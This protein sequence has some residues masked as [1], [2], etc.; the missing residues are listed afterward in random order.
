MKLV[1]GKKVR[2][3]ELSKFLKVSKELDYVNNTMRKY[4]GEVATVVK[5]GG[6]ICKLNIDNQLY[7]WKKEYLTK[8]SKPK[9][10][11]MWI[12]MDRDGKVFLSGL[13]PRLDKNLGKF[14][15]NIDD[16]HYSYIGCDNIVKTFF[17]KLTFENS[18]QRINLSIEIIA[19]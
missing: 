8:F 9:T 4:C 1:E 7:W 12:A 3:L 16:K 17:P 10:K 2:I 11:K 15:G 18:P 13:K 14:L 5:A 19:K 6:D